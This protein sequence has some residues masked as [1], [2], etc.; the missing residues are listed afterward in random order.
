MFKIKSKCMNEND[1]IVKEFETAQE[2]TEYMKNC[3][4]AKNLQDVLK[5][6]KEYNIRFYVT[7]KK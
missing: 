1:Y 3:C 4:N 6:Q 7:L 2:V 5:A